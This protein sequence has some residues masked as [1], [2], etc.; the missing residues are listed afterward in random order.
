MRYSRLF[1]GIC[2]AVLLAAE[3]LIGLFATGFVRGDIGDVLIVPLL[4]AV[5]RTASPRRPAHNGLLPALLLALA[6][7][8]E[9]MQLI[10]IADILNVQDMFLRT[11]IG[12]SFSVGDLV[13]YAVG[14]L[15]LF[16]YELIRRKEQ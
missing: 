3:I 12:T 6:F 4:Y 9:F 2:S 1:Y 8:T 7:L 14:A 15:P 10:G 13:C 5:Y 11:V 16:A